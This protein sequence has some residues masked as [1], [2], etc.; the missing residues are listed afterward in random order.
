MEQVFFR[1][2]L[3]VNL[4][5]VTIAMVKSL[6]YSWAMLQQQ[7]TAILKKFSSKAFVEVAIWSKKCPYLQF[8]PIN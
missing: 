2:C 1:M 4:S 5:F 3:E 7:M 8:S 6:Q